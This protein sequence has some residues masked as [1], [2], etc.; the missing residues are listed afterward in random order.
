MPTVL[1]GARLFDG[2]GNA[3]VEQSMIVIRD[4]RIEAVGSASTM[5]VPADA[6]HVDLSGKTIL[7]GFVNAHGHLNTV[8]PDASPGRENLLAQLRLYARY[9][10]TTVV[11]LGIGEEVLD[12]ALQLRDEQQAGGALDGARLLVAGPSLQNLETAA[13]A[14]ERVNA[15]A[16]AGVDIVKLHVTGGPDDMTPEVY[17][18]LIDQ[19]HIR[20]LAVAAHIYFLADAR[21]LVDAGVD[22]LAHSVRDQD[23][24][25]A[26]IGEIKRR[27]VGYTPTLTRDLARFVYE[28]T[29]AFVSDPFFLQSVAAYRGELDRVTDPAYQAEMRNSEV[30]QADK[31]G[32][33]QGS[34]N[35][36]IA[37]DAGITIGL[38]TDSGTNVGQWQGY[39][40]HTELEMMVEAGLS[41][42]QALV[43]ATGG[44]ARVM[45]LDED[46]GTVQPGR[47]ADL[48]VLDANPLDDIRATRQIHSV[49]IA[50]RRLNLP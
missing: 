6:V 39:F 10:V 15:Y 19:A 1:T 4:G 23:L 28:S 24:D 17:G 22:V 50:G 12:A 49:W 47:W 9:G 30:R 8:M 34:R 18:A 16:D 25:A 36:K 48:V 37:S 26:L 40:E 31:I 38:G 27:D 13:E 29:P 21:G 41:P 2:T 7:P 3:P 46:L 42:A 11:V 44:A 45:A 5:T 33:R 35:L 20:G 43:A 32:L 14:R